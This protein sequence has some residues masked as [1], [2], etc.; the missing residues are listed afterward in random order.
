[1]CYIPTTLKGKNFNFLQ[2]WL[3]FYTLAMC[4]A[5]ILDAYVCVYVTKSQIPSTVYIVVKY[6]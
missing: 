2:L 6:A 5:E 1:M 3:R 4:S